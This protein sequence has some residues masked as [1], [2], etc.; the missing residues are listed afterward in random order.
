MLVLQRFIGQSIRVGES[1]L[2]RAARLNRSTARLTL[3]IT[4]AGATT[5]AILQPGGTFI[6]LDC[7]RVSVEFVDMLIERRAVRLGIH[8]PREMHI[9]RHDLN[10][11][12]PES[13]AVPIDNL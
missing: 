9:V 1:I 8:A 4:V 3:E 11:I 10:S 12:H 13:P 2:V 7:P 6:I 5:D